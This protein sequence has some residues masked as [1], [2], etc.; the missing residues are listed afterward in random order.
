KVC[1]CD[2]RRRRGELGE[3]CERWRGHGSIIERTGAAYYLTGRSRAYRTPV[4]PLKFTKFTEVTRATGSTRARG[5][6]GPCFGG[7][8]RLQQQSRLRGQPVQR[9]IRMTTQR[10]VLSAPD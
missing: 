7:A 8:K 1:D 6:R 10:A 4:P 5:L 9:I 3:L 2:R